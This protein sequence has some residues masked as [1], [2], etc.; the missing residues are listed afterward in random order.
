MRSPEHGSGTE[1]P[2]EPDESLDGRRRGDARR[3]IKFAV[4]R[5][6]LG[7]FQSILGVNCRQVRYG[8]PTSRVTSLYFDDARLSA[9]RLNLDGVSRRTK[10]RLRWYDTPFPEVRAFFEVKKRL[11]EAVVKERVA[12]RPRLPP[13]PL[14]LRRL[15]ERLASVLPSGHSE[16]LL[17]R[18]E[19]VLMVE[20]ERAYFEAVGEPVRLTVDNDLTFYPQMGRRFATRRFAE[21]IADLVILELKTPLGNEGR[22]RDLLHPLAPWLSRSS[23]YVMGCQYL[24]LVSGGHY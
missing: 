1:Q 14:L 7:K 17:A 12:L 21:R 19:P 16:L 5:A 15:P 23:K 6:D 20:Y 13:G 3:E 10:L 2:F 22:L 24:G 18:G 9:C 8:N 4:R 11:D